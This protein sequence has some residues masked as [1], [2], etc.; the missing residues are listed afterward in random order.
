MTANEHGGKPDFGVLL[1]EERQ[2]RKLS[3]VVLISAALGAGMIH[4]QTAPAGVTTRSI[5]AVQPGLFEVAGPRVN[6]ALAAGLTKITA[7]PG[8]G[9]K[10]IYVE[11]PW[12]PIYFGWPKDVKPVAFTIQTGKAGGKAAEI[13]APGFT[14]GNKGDYKAA[15]DAVIPMAISKAQAQK[16]QNSSGFTL[17]CPVHPKLAEAIKAVPSAHLT[18]IVTEHGKPFTAAGFGNWMRHRCNEAGLPQCTSHGL[19][20]GLGRRLAEAQATE[21]QI[22][23]ILGHS[24]IRRSQIYTR[25]AD[26][27][28]MAHDGMALLTETFGP[29]S[30]HS[31]PNRP[32]RFGNPDE[33]VNDLNGGHTTWRPFLDT[34]RTMCLAP[35]PAF[36]RILE[37]VQELR[38][39]A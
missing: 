33:N 1:N 3:A 15:L 27:K 12:G 31:L 11:S 2:M 38:F 29:K 19:R 30:E 35:E 5:K 37:D 28:L 13:S 24:D 17:E 8:M 22:A 7:A 21:R 26:K 18:F 36:R 4:A 23:S 10:S 16:T 6:E 25:D 9:G 39:A 14:E 20:K 34:Y 32:T